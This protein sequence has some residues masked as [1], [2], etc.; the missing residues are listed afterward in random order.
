MTTAELPPAPTTPL[1]GEVSVAVLADG[2]PAAFTT[3][4][5]PGGLLRLD[6]T[7]PDG[8]ALEVRLAT[9]LREAAGFW[10]PACGWSRTLLPDWAGRMRASLVNG[11]VAGCLYEASGAT[12]MSFAALDPAAEAE[13]VFGV[14]EQARRFVA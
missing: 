3:R 6:V 8:A 7:A 14:S 2:V 11:A 10:H 12:L 1:L 5:L 13:V 9:P 4:P